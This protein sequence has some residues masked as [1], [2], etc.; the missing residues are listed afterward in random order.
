[1]AWAQKAVSR[2]GHFREDSPQVAKYLLSL[3]ILDLS[4]LTFSVFWVMLKVLLLFAPILFM[5]LISFVSSKVGEIKESTTK[6][7]DQ[8]RERDRTIQAQ[9]NRNFPER[10]ERYK[11]YNG[12]ARVKLA[13]HRYTYVKT[14][15]GKD[16]Y[17]KPDA[18]YVSH[19]GYVVMKNDYPMKNVFEEAEDFIRQSAIVKRDRRAALLGVDGKYIIPFNN[20]HGE[21]LFSDLRVLS[22]NCLEY[23][24]TFYGGRTERRIINRNGQTLF[25]GFPVRKQIIDDRL[26]ID[27][28]GQRMEIDTVSAKVLSPLCLSYFELENGFK[29]VFSKKGKPGWNVFDTIS[30]RLLFDKPHQ[31]IVYLNKR[32]SYLVI[33]DDTIGITDEK[34]Q[35]IREM[36]GEGIDY[37]YNQQYFYG[38][39]ELLGFDGVSVP[40]FPK[41]IVQVI[42]DEDEP[43]DTIWWSTY[44]HPT[45]TPTEPPYH[46]MD[47]GKILFFVCQK[48]FDYTVVDLQGKT[49]VGPVNY[50]IHVESDKRNSFRFYDFFSH[51]MRFL[52][53]DDELGQVIEPSLAK[54][55]NPGTHPSSHIK[56]RDTSN[57]SSRKRIIENS[58]LFFD[59][60]TTGIPANYDAPISD[61][62]NWPRLVQLSWILTDSTGK[63]LGI[64]DYIIKPDGFTIPV[65]STSVHGISTEIAKEKGIT[66]RSV[67]KE[68]VS[69]LKSAG[70]IV[71]HNVD[72]DRNVI[73]AEFLRAKIDPDLLLNKPTICTMKA[74]TDYCK[75]P[76][77]YGYKWPT[78]QELHNKLFDVNFE[79][80]HNSLNDIKATKDCFFEMKAR[81]II[82]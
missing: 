57:S 54:E 9:V 35:I 40:G 75:L 17:M 81:K 14:V 24:P 51:K 48:D 47:R 46:L 45:K 77:K 65:E 25:E 18:D 29:M 27:D 80:A 1:M 63:E 2:G 79:D 56:S 4:A 26:I 33:D 70:T 42:H 68:F 61:L 60:E 5:L 50:P 62:E 16:V 58:Y 41:Q 19:G 31:C 69:D 37:L 67:L 15:D 22:G 21:I 32:N 7:R 74:S 28:G 78:L 71:G 6:K 55:K 53:Y 49:I 44:I 72:F 10:Q 13:E 66:L 38:K 43:R 36:N 23:V 76:G 59:T 30:Q 20:S 39:S 73:G 34:G 52:S 64:K 8:N 82:K 3:T 12:W 11:A